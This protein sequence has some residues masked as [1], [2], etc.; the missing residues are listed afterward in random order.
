MRNVRFS[1]SRLIVTALLL[2]LVF[3]ALW[4]RQQISDWFR[5]YGYQPDA[6]VSRLATDD[7]LTAKGTHLFYINRPAVVEST[8]FKSDCPQ[9]EQ[10]IVLGCYRPYEAGIY[11][12]KIAS[13]SRLNG[14]MQV[15]AAHEMLHAAYDRLSPTERTQVNAW[16][17]AYYH[18]GL[19]DERIK[20]T[21]AAYKTTEPNDV[22]NEMHSVFGTEVADLPP[23]LEHYYQQYFAK[24]SAITDLAS[25]YQA[26]FTNRE[27]A[28]KQYD[29]QLKDMKAEINND[30]AV[31]KSQQGAI[32]RQSQQLAALK[33]EG[34]IADYNQGV[35]SYNQAVHSYNALVGTTR[36]LIAE[37]N[38]IVVRRNA[39]ASEQQQLAHE[40]SGGPVQAITK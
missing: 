30:E 36:Q 2:L 39:I 6:S 7:N 15:T 13:D 29:A 20:Q 4:Y 35:G 26:E 8:S 25:S 16:L 11:V 23:N 38:Q 32:N 28:I 34:R 12:L 3:G 14:V 9:H 22:V 21:I 18:D 24:R 27:Q 5:L 10:T 1:R 17:L 37:Y 40:L 33:N 19:T 31:L